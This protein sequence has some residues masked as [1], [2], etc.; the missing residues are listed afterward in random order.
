METPK[1][2]TR[3]RD[4]RYGVTFSVESPGAVKVEGEGIPR[5]HPLIA[6]GGFISTYD[7]SVRTPYDSLL[8][9]C[10][11][12]E[13]CDFLGTRLPPHYEGGPVGDFV[14]QTY[15]HVLKRIHNFAA[16][17]SASLSLAPQSNVGLFSINRP[18][19]VY[20]V[21]ICNIYSIL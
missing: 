8:K 19:W 3:L 11:E 10:S 14:F 16:G 5:R 6:N 2:S 13:G 12:F 20:S 1:P 4:S 9:S 21:I 7:E 18:E 17:L 15:G